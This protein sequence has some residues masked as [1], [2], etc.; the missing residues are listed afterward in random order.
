MDVS[1]N[2]N[3][4][5]AAGLA[6]SDRKFVLAASMGGRVEVE[7]GRAAV[8][9]AASDAN[10]TTFTFVIPMAGRPEG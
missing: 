6:A 5:M 9:H 1:G 3:A 10:G 4:N 7:L 2:M 8:T